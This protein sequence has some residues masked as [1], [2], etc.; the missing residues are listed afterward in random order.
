MHT[1]H[2]PVL[3][4]GFSV[5]AP[6][7][8]ARYGIASVM[9]LVDDSLME[10]LRQFYLNKF[11]KEYI[12]IHSKEND[13]RAKRITAYLNMVNQFVKEQFESLRNSTFETGS[14]IIKYLEMLPDK[15]LIKIKYKNYLKN[16][17]P[18]NSSCL[19]NFIRQNITPGS[20]D[21]NIMT[22]VDRANYDIEGKILSAEYNDAHAALRGFALSDLESSIVFSAG[23]N[24]KLYSYLAT[25]PDFYPG[26]N[27]EFKKKIIIKVS[28]FRSADIQSKFLAKKGLWVSE[29]R[30]ESG[31][32][33]GGH[34]FAS[35]GLLL[36]PILEEFKMKRENLQTSLRGLCM[37]VFAEK[38]IK[39]DPEELNIRITVQG[40][41]G[42]A[43]EHEFLMRNYNVDSIGW[44]SP[45]LLVPE[46]MNVDTET[47]DKLSIADEDDFYL[48]YVSPLGVPFNNLK[49]SEKDLEKM[50]RIDNNKPGSPCVRKFLES[51]TEFSEK[52]ICTAAI[53]YIKQKIS[54]LKKNSISE[55]DYNKEVAKT[56]DKVC[57]CEGLIASALIVNKI[58]SFKQSMKV[59]VC[60]GPNLAYFNKIVTLKEMVE[61]IYGK[62]N[63]ITHT[64]RMNM[65]MKE[66]SLNIDFYKKKIE[67]SIEPW[68]VNTSK[69][70]ETFRN[71]LLDGISYYKKLIPDIIE[72]SAEVRT[73]IKNDLQALEEK[74]LSSVLIP[75]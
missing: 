6:L 56:V 60:P 8:V 5:D 24:P 64:N 71:N 15:S 34:A 57:L 67:D 45:F 63:I 38:N 46:V 53:S 54:D 22:K 73:K 75:G 17:D 52:P 61:H 65:F 66:L 29:F 9:S 31:L 74:L 39:I 10:K 14:E 7:K 69:M 44:G 27:N 41:V 25:F 1:F 50:N 49:G 59:A 47:L 33:C 4:V 62:V 16:S 20:L 11:N 12:P 28:D 42:E 36:G 19:A 37:K 30:I 13:S 18:S 48:S 55:I 3:G 23:I 40:G 2:I 68:S 32:N 72:E 58:E 70:L 35:D 51:N 43:S 26:E 21:V